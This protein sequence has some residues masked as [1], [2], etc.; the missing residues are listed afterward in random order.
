MEIR[1][2]AR[3]AGLALAGLALVAGQAAAA[4]TFDAATGQGFVGKG[5]VQVPWGWNNATLQQEAE[6]VDFFSKQV[7][8]TDY[9]LTCE[10]DTGNKKKVHH[11]QTTK[12]AVEDAIEY[13]VTKATRKNPKGAVTG[14][15]LLGYGRT[16]SSQSSG[17]PIP[18]VGAGCPGNSGQGFV[19]DVE[20]VSSTS[21]IELFARDR[22]AGLGPTS[23]YAPS[24]GGDAPV[25]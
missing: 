22:A 15:K 3:A 20:I 13:D 5:D 19:T 7:D 23:I 1:P 24:L 11:V 4:V 18:T 17:D 25:A 9:E 12:K 14:F 10:W 2:F 21:T 6:N 16:L 8:E